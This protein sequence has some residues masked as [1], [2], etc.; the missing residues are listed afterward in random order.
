MGWVK[1]VMF[2]GNQGSFIFG[3]VNFGWHNALSKS[4]YYEFSIIF[5]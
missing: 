1:E 2:G 5:E 3:N 4:T